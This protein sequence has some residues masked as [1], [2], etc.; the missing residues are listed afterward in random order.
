MMTLKKVKPA[1][2]PL[3]VAQRYTIEEAIAYLRSSRKSV[4]RLINTGEL[5]TLKENR[6]RYV[7]GS[8]IARHSRLEMAIGHE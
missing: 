7:P 8:E 4:Y 5:K 1:L 3:D 6:R 2:P